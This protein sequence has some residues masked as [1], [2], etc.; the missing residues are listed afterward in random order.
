MDQIRAV[1][2]EWTGTGQRFR[3]RGIEPVAPEVILDGDT[4]LGASPMLHLLMAAAGCSGIDVVMI[5]HKMRVTVTHCAIRA[6]GRRRDE[7][8]RRFVS[9]DLHFT[10]SGEGLDLRKARRAVELS[11][12]KYCSVIHSLAQDTEIRTHVEIR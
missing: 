2:V 11:V 7:E 10:L 12:Q 3:A 1:E 6:T 4:E 9:L 5:L 8:P